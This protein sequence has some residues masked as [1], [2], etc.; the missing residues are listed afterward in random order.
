MI[1]N[2][3]TLILGW[4][5]QLFTIISE[6]CAANASRARSTI[7]V[8]ANHDKIDMEG[9]IRS[10]V[11][12]TGSTQVICRRGNPLDRH[13]LHL[14][15]PETARSV[16]VLPSD[17]DEHPDALV[18]KT[19]LALTHQLPPGN[20][21]A[22]VAELID[23]L[24]L[25]AARLAGQG[26][27]RW[28]LASELIS[29]MTVQTCLQGGLSTV[30]TELLDFAGDEIYFTEQPQLVGVSYLEAQCAFSRSTV[31]GIARGEDVRLNPPAETAIEKGDQLILIAADDSTIECVAPRSADTTVISD[32]IE[33]PEQPERILVLGSNSNLQRM[34]DDLAKY[35]APGSS[36]HVVTDST[37]P[38]PLPP[39]GLTVGVTRADTTS[40]HV[41]ERLGVENYG[42]VLVLAYHDRYDVQVADSKTLVTLLHLRDIADRAALDINIV[43]EMLD[44][45]NRELAEVARPDD[46]IVSSRL[47][48]L[49]LAQVSENSELITVF[50][51]LFSGDG[52]EI[53]VVPSELY[54]RD[55]AEADFYTV[56]AAAARRQET[57]LGYRI[58]EDA[59]SNVKSYGV[60]LNPPKGE[61]RTFGP[62]DSIIVLAENGKGTGRAPQAGVTP[63]MD[64]SG[65]ARSRHRPERAIGR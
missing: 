4:N 9:Q 52:S 7:V 10:K 39:E 58:A 51:Q 42:H 56:T 19:A 8:L 13:D 15:S 31:I 53:Y 20:E 54:I 17:K 33:V 24:N 63:A 25:D 57:A 2:G 62:G 48:S 27:A 49:M 60:H 22:I 44:D 12:K 5:S 14:G 47:V 59:Y 23:P 34:L 45:R 41:L 43:S 18:I 3:H 46:F 37:D 30:C 35:L 61:R 21:P 11:H 36:V 1:E 6:L 50:E 16:V 26:R 55:G 65:A 38:A 29:R 32:L 64:R 28:L 40:R